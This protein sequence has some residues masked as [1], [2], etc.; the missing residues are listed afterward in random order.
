MYSIIILNRNIRHLPLYLLLNI[1][2][3]HL[4]RCLLSQIIPPLYVLL[5]HVIVKSVT[6]ESAEYFLV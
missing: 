2:L 4:S 3:S 5:T 6:V 1:V